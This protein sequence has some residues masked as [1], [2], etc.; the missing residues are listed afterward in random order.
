VLKH[1][2][3]TMSTS[4]IEKKG[5]KHEYQQLLTLSI[6]I[7]SIIGIISVKKIL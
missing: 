2:K 4:I 5:K 1:F 7:T 3:S 6:N